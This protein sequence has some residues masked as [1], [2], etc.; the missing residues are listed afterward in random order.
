MMNRL[1]V[2]VLFFFSW[3][4]F[5]SAQSP[6]ML[7]VLPSSICSPY[8]EITPILTKDGKTLFFTRV[9]SP[10]F[11]R[12]KLPLSESDLGNIE[13]SL[14]ELSGIYAE[15]SGTAVSDPVGS[16]FN[17]DV[18]IGILDGNLIRR[19]DHPKQ[20]LN[21]IFP[22]SV[23]SL[24]PDPNSFYVVNRINSE[25]LLEKG[26]SVIR[27]E[28]GG[29]SMPTPVEIED[30]YTLTSDVSLTMSGDGKV[31]LLSATRK[32]G[33]NMDLFCLLQYRKRYLVSTTIFGYHHQYRK[34]RSYTLS[35]G[36]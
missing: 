14:P 26:F 17:Q 15:I 16:S 7:E 36:R 11:E 20:P 4:S 21:N 5:A 23:V 2:L 31:L 32:D 28:G 30:Y 13:V 27:R 33:N 29:W 24:T 25:G 1:Q 22:N 35:I 6:F 8:D 12:T 10:D 18:W 9:G 34:S 19:V 3:I